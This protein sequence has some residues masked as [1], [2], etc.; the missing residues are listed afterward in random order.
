MNNRNK[1]IEPGSGTGSGGNRRMYNCDICMRGFTNPQALGG[2]RN[3]HRKERERILSSSSSS[4]QSLPFSTSLPSQSLYYTNPS[5][6]NPRPY[7]PTIDSYHYQTFQPPTNPSYST[8]RFETS[9]SPRRGNYAQG[10]SL[11]L[12]LSLRLGSVDVGNNSHQWLQGAGVSQPEQDDDLDL[13]LRLG[14]HHHR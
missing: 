3:L 12:D 5:N 2:H 7:F 9:S 10:E 13:N 6:N 8:Q 11:G 14:G 1:Q 4:S